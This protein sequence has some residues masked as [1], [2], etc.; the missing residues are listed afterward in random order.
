MTQNKKII[1]VGDAGVGK[2]N[3]IKR[4]INKEFEPRYKETIIFKSYKIND[5]DIIDTPGQY[6]YDIK[7]FYPKVKITHCI[8]MYD[9]TSNMSYNYII[10]Y[11]YNV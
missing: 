10:G 4:L 9:V 6:K 1:I 11:I 7:R 5:I 3:F 2:T 8:I